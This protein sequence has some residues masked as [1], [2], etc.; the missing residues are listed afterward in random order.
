MLRLRRDLIPVRSE[1]FEAAAFDLFVEQHVIIGIKG[2][3]ATEEDVDDDAK[4]PDVTRAVVPLHPQH[5][6]R[7]VPR[8]TARRLQRC[9]LRVEELREPKVGDLDLCTWAAFG[10]EHILRLEITVGDPHAVQVLDRIEQLDR[11]CDRIR[12]GEKLK[13]KRINSEIWGEWGV[14]YGGNGCG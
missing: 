14:T 10:H 5:L 11:Q 2:R 8:R 4:A 1:E 3:E 7:Y 6:W 9:A 12:L 13:K